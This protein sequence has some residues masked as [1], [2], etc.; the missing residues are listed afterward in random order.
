MQKFVHI[1]TFAEKGS[2]VKAQDI[3][4]TINPAPVEPAADCPD[5]DSECG[6]KAMKKEC[7]TDR[8]WMV[9]DAARPGHCLSTCLRC[10]IWRQHLRLVQQQQ[11]QEDAERHWQ[12]QQ[13]RQP[14]LQFE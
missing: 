9:G 10:D 11:E 14:G 7:H 4:P 3:H 6:I 13:R 8:G 1:G 2:G 12:W 5:M